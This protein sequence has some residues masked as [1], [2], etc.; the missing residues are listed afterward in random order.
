MFSFLFLRVFLLS[1]TKSFF[2]FSLL[3]LMKKR[4]PQQNELS[5]E[6]RRSIV[7]KLEIHI[8]YWTDTWTKRSQK[9]VK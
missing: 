5:Y 7:S 6:F 3:N 4:K 8:Q 9:Q 1:F 2:H